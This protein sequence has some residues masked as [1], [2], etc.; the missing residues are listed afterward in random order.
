MRYHWGFAIGHVYTHGKS[1]SGVLTDQHND[2]HVGGDAETHVAVEAEAQGLTFDTGET[3]DLEYS[4]DPQDDD[5]LDHLGA[6]DMSD[7]GEGSDVGD[8]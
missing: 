4:L 2:E 8:G 5:I 7:D 1:Q 6:S 3:E